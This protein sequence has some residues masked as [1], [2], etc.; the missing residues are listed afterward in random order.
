MTTTDVASADTNNANDL[1]LNQLAAR[2]SAERQDAAE[3]SYRHAQLDLRAW[4]AQVHWADFKTFLEQVANVEPDYICLPEGA[5]PNWAELREVGITDF[6]AYSRGF[7]DGAVELAKE[8][9]GMT[10]SAPATDAPTDNESPDVRQQ[11]EE[12]QWSL[13]EARLQF[14]ALATLLRTGPELP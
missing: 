2:F 12:A 7:C 5:V 8:L 1:N 3:H 9:E 4:A 14:E 11:L 6:D 13:R 10:Q